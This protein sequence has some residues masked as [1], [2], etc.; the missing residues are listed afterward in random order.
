[1]SD[2]LDAKLTKEEFMDTVVTEL[3]KSAIREYCVEDG[4]VEYVDYAA[5]EIVYTYPK[6][7]EDYPLSIEQYAEGTLSSG[8]I[9]RISESSPS[10]AIEKCRAT[11][12]RQTVDK[13][14]KSLLDG[15][16]D[17]INTEQKTVVENKAVTKL[18]E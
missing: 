10:E 7:L 15:E 1:M 9:E 13:R 16:W 12:L 11:M 8:D 4:V 2:S 6:Y 14:I 5:G 18:D 17:A 3:A